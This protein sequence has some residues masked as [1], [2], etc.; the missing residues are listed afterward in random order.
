MTLYLILIENP[1][2]AVLTFAITG[3]IVG[4]KG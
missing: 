2:L 3:L 1:L 4:A